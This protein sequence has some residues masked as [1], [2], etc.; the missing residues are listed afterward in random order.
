MKARGA[1]SSVEALHFPWGDRAGR[2]TA[3][4]AYARG[5]YLELQQKGC[6][7]GAVEG[8]AAALSRKSEASSPAARSHS[9]H[10]FATPNGRGRIFY[11]SRSTFHVPPFVARSRVMLKARN[12]A[13]VKIMVA[14]SNTTLAA[15]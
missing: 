8:D 2:C 13:K 12:I 9:S 15:T 11:L 3:R 4:Q 10:L 7:A 14:K 5:G 6:G 1:C